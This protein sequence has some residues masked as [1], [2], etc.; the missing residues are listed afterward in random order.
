MPP[1]GKRCAEAGLKFL[2]GM[3][4]M[5]KKVVSALFLLA[6]LASAALSAP[7]IGNFES[8]D[9]QGNPVD[10]GLFQNARLTVLNVWGTF[11]PPC[12]RELPA[13]GRLSAEFAPQ[14]VQIVGLVSDWFDNL[15]RPDP[16]QIDKARLLVK[17]TGADYVH[18]LLNAS[19]MEHLGR[20]DA[21][22]QTFFVNS[23]GEIIGAVTG[24]RSEG[25]WR[26]IFNEMLGKAEL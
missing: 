24:A 4:A 26:A 5:K 22:P 7:R 23:R 8:V 1:A 18:A 11:C 12:L 3:I 15:G 14:G 25:N 10:Q 2:K 6:M 21:V 13:L 9:L 16:R 20:I 19:L 17:K